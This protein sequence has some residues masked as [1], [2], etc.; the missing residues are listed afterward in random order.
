MLALQQFGISTDGHP[1]VAHF[2]KWV[3]H[4]SFSFQAVVGGLVQ[5]EVSLKAKEQSGRQVPR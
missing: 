1:C 2:T 3:Q 4:F 5:L